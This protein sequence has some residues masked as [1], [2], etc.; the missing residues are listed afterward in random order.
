LRPGTPSISQVKEQFGLQPEHLSSILQID[1]Y[2]NAIGKVTQVFNE[3]S[4][5]N[6][7][8]LFSDDRKVNAPTAAPGQGLPSTYG[9]NRV[10]DLYYLRQITECAADL[11]PLVL[12]VAR[13]FTALLRRSDDS[14]AQ[15]SV[16]RYR[17]RTEL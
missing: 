16:F 8:Y 11:I 12:D 7:G 1:N 9:D 13:V 4:I 2:D 14:T 3:R 15:V 6:V 17:P 5:L 10:Q